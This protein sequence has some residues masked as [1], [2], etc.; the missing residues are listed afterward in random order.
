MI[1][2]NSLSVFLLHHHLNGLGN[3]NF[4]P[5]QRVVRASE[6][7]ADKFK[8]VCED[9]SN[10]AILT[11]SSTLGKIQLPFGHAAFGNKSLGESVVA[12]ALAG[13]LS[14]PSVI[15]L[16]IEIAFAV[17]GDKI[18]LPIVEVLLRTTAA[19]L[20]RSKKQRDWTPRNDV[21]LPTFLTEAAILHS[22]SD[23][24]KLLKIFA[25]S[26]T[27]WAKDEDSTSKADEANDNDS[28]VTIDAEE[29]KSMPGKAKQAS[30]ETAAAETLATIKNDCDDVL[31]FLQAVV[32]KSP[33]VIAAAL[34]LHTYKRT[35]L[36][37]TLDRRQ[38]SQ[39]A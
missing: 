9:F 24:G 39:A 30:D 35:H 29:A 37:P 32:I 19:N 15:S 23:V 4:C 25:R 5:I 22:E 12:F 34:P 28:V 2:T 33:R 1:S 8:R 38:P 16:K 21:L 13:N 18:R 11:K 6:P 14:S 31:A 3:K 10:L 36:V 27:E 17:D 26:I 20:T 7:A